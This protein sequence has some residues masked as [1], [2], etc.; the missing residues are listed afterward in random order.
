MKFSLSPKRVGIYFCDGDG[1]IAV[2]CDA[3]VTAHPNFVE[4]IRA[5]RTAFFQIYD[6]T[7][8]DSPN[9]DHLRDATKGM[10]KDDKA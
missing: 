2:Q 4:A 3:N 6:S 5:A 7:L 9:S 10:E 8:D 1:A